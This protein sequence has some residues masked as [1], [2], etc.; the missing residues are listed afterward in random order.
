MVIKIKSGHKILI[1]KVDLPII[2]NNVFYV[3]KLGYPQTSK[4]VTL[5]RL[6][7]N[8]P[9]GW[10]IDHINRNKLDNRRN[11]LRLVTHRENM[12][13]CKLSKNNKSGVNGVSWS[14][15]YG[16]WRAY[17]NRYYKQ[18]SLGYFSK[19]ED[20]TLARQKWEN[21]YG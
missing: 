14:S 20:A 18:I 6:I 8:S 19:L 4:G 12:M 15:E 1:D 7:M 21:I 9:N 3:T 10:S 17:G 11:N 5:H 2:E 13:N 16:K